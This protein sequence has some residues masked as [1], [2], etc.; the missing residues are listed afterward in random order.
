MSVI[1]DLERKRQSLR[2]QL[3]QVEANLANARADA[4]G[5]KVGDLIEIDVAGFYQDSKWEGPHRVAK[6]ISTPYS[7]SLTYNV[8]TKGGQWSKRER[9]VYGPWRHCQAATVPTLSD[10][11]PEGAPDYD[12]PSEARRLK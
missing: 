5:V 12:G 11:E 10:N 2:D 4:A 6:V 7:V 3:R 1:D 8:R 9:N